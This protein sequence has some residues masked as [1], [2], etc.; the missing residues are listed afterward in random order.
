MLVLIYSIIIIFCIVGIIF[1]CN[2][3]KSINE[4]FTDFR[5][6]KKPEIKYIKK[7]NENKLEEINEN[8]QKKQYLAYFAFLIIQYLL[9]VYSAVFCN[10]TLSLFSSNIRIL[11][12]V[13]YIYSTKFFIYIIHT[14]AYSL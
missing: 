9:M 8:Q 12:S 13:I 7:I 14:I 5:K 2:D 1:E 10:S 11:K 4:E 6:D 3:Y